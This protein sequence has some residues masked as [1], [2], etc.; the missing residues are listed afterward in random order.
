M[1]LQITDNSQQVLSELNS[2]IPVILDVLAQ[3]AEANGVLEI[4]A[5]GAVDTGNL[6][7]SISHDT[8]DTTAYVGTNVEY[9]PYV[10]MG[11]VKMPARPFLRN[12]V[13]NH[14]EEYKAIIENGLKA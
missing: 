2:K 6:R 13:E 11:T 9:A 1:E 5:L 14:K 3:S 8:D 10:E 7:D 4:T 12:A